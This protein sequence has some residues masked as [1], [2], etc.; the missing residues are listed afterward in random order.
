MGSLHSREGGCAA[1]ARTSN[2]ILTSSPVEQRQDEVDPEGLKVL[3]EGL[4]PHPADRCTRRRT[5]AALDS[6]TSQGRQPGSMAPGYSA[7]AGDWELWAGFRSTAVVPTRLG[8]LAGIRG[9]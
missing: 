3:G 5:A 2:L 7:G 9:S 8:G 6:H 1:R 4:G